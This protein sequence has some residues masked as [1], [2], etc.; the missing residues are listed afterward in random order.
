MYVLTQRALDRPA[1]V[2]QTQIAIFWRGG[3][4]LILNC[5]S[6]LYILENDPLLEVSFANISSHFLGCLLA[7]FFFFN[8]SFS[9][10]NLSS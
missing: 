7:F 9:L 4:F 1:L 5:M 6:C 10:Q 2:P 8:I 3:L